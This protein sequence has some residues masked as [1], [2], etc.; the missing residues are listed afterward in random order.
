MYRYK[1]MVMRLVGLKSPLEKSI[2]KK[3][4]N[5]ENTGMIDMMYHQ[6]Q[7]CTIVTHFTMP[8]TIW[9]SWIRR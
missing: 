1:L 2:L 8:D 7:R 3:L 4:D 9:Q 6:L 5:L